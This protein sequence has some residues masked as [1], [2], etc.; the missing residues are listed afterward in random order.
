[1]KL[2]TAL[3]LTALTALL[4]GPLPAGDMVVFGD[5]LSDGGYLLG[6]R[7]T[8]GDLWHETLADR[9]GHERATVS[10]G[11]F[12]PG[13]SGL[14]LAVS[15]SRVTDLPSQVDRYQSRH[16]WQSGDLCTLWIGGNDLRD[17]PGQDMAALC[18]RI[19]DVIADLASHQIDHFLVPNLPDLGAIPEAAGDPTL[20]AARRAGTINFNTALAA[21]MANRATTLGVTIDLLDVFGMF[22][23]LLANPAD[24]GFTN[25]SGSLTTASPD[26]NPD[27]YVF[28]DDIHPTTRSHFL[29]GA[30]AHVLL[31]PD[32][33]GIEIISWS[34]SQSGALRQTWLATPAA[35]YEILS[36]PRPDALTPAASF[37]GSPAYT[38]TVPAPGNQAGF[39][40][41]R[42]N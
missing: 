2:P 32:G 16:T 25:T 5:S 11:L 8:N 24:Y 26:V 7:F 40:Q 36:G 19:G 42:R 29:L 20:A 6:L 38:A 22:D 1:M 37:L 18:A 21:E 28:Y 35:S 14:N 33:A 39:Y 31:D 23:Q 27:Q 41:T 17:D 10:G 12:N 30:A 15:A 13:S 9:L 4:A 3:A 34:I